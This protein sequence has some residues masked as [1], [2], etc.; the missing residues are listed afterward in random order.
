MRQKG[1]IASVSVRSWRGYFVDCS[2]GIHVVVR[3]FA[4]EVT[5]SNWK[6]RVLQFE[7]ILDLKRSVVLYAALFPFEK[8]SVVL[9]IVF[10]F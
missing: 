5:L 2:G 8:S 10:C 1:I 6:P 4:A 3:H 7:F 9:E